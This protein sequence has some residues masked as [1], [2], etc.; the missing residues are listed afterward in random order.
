MRRRWSIGLVAV[1]GCLLVGSF[2]SPASAEAACTV[3][4][5]YPLTGWQGGGVWRVRGYAYISGCTSRSYHVELGLGEELQPGN[6]KF[7]AIQ[8]YDGPETANHHSWPVAVNCS[9]YGGTGR[10]A[11]MWRINGGARHRSSLVHD[12][13]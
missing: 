8:H 12:I 3:S 7:T 9:N 13:C 11:T 2:S 1:V 6:W 10:F 4:P 5:H